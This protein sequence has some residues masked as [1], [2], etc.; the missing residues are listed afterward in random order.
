MALAG[1]ARSRPRRAHFGVD[2]ALLKPLVVDGLGDQLTAPEGAHHADHVLVQIVVRV[3]DKEAAEFEF[4]RIGNLRLLIHHQL[5]EHGHVV[6]AV[7]F[8]RDEKLVGLVLRELFE[9]LQHDAI[10]VFSGHLVAKANVVEKRVLAV[11]EADTCRLLHIEDVRLLGP[12]VPVLLEL[13]AVLGDA[14]RTML[15]KEP[16]QTTASRAAVRPKQHRRVGRVLLGLDE[17]VKDIASFSL[18]HLKVA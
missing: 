10:V 6:A 11:R 18:V 1:H 2:D 17:P 16:D 13:V 14:E 4:L 9:E 8:R 3:A 5:R 12:S 7:A 15:G